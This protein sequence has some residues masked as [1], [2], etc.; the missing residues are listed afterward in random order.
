MSKFASLLF[1]WGTLKKAFSDQVSRS[2]ILTSLWQK[3]D[4]KT[5][6]SPGTLP[7]EILSKEQIYEKVAKQKGS[8]GPLLKMNQGFSYA[9]E[10]VKFYRHGVLSVWQN[11][12]K[13]KQ[14]RKKKFKIGGQL[15]N[16]GQETAISLPNFNELTK[17]MA[18]ALYMNF[19]ENRTKA[20]NTSSDV[21]R[22]DNTVTKVL[23]H[24]LFQLT[25]AE[26]QLLRRTP[27]DFAKIPMF[28]ILVTIFMEMTP[29]V[30]YAFPEVTPS[31][32]VLPSIVPRIWNSKSGKKLRATVTKETVSSLDD[33][34]VKTAFNLPLEHVHL[35]A[36]TLRLKSK[37]IPSSLY[38]ESVLRDRLQD[39]YN[40][41]TVDNYYLSGLNGDGNLWGLN[42]SE[43]ILACL[44]RNL[45]DDIEGLVKIQS[46]G[47]AEEK[48]E[49]LERL[50]LKLFQFIVNFQQCNIGYLAIGHLLPQPDGSAITAW[51]NQTCT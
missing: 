33:Y 13:M 2:Q 21:V 5:I 11:N 51:R 26:Y 15:E 29:V 37:Y 46:L 4:A 44:A 8:A 50:R 42:I 27:S 19:V 39:Y 22:A 14:I 35:L 47:A 28:A 3:T 41:L 1:L 18:Q 17:H 9:K 31:T 43:L 30:C 38:P 40:Y 49:E 36:D 34:A 20:E 24:G 10:L 7:L 32:C 25:R 16:S 45:V 23:D 48:R 12:K 6:N